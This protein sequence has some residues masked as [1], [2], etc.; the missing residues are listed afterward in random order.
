MKETISSL[1]DKTK[2]EILDILFNPEK[3]GSSSDN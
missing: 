2:K 3:P 1:M